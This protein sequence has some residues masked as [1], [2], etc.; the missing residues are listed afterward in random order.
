MSGAGGGS[1]CARI[2]MESARPCHG[3]VTN[4]S[5]PSAAGGGWTPHIPSPGG[6]MEDGLR[7]ASG[8]AEGRG[9]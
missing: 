9:Q 2:G 1:S 3:Q 5:V 8:G 6:A 4:S 7:W